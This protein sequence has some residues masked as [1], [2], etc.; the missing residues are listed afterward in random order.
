MTESVTTA[1]PAVLILNWRD[2][3]NP[4]GGGS[5]LYAEEVAAGLARRGHQVTIFCAAHDRA[6]ADELTPDG[7][8]MMRRG[9]PRGVYFRAFWERLRGRLG[10]F[11]VVV[12]V[13]NGLPFLARL[14]A[15]KPVV[16]LIHHVHREQWRVVLGPLAAR[17]GWWVES[18]LS[19][20]VHRACR[21]VTVSEVTRSE[22]AELGV[23]RERVTIVHN[24]TPTAT[25]PR[26]QRTEEPSLLVLGRLVPHKRV[27][28]AIR[29]VAELAPT[30]PGAD[31]HGGRPRLVAGPAA[32]RGRAAR[33]RRPGA[34]HRFRRRRRQARAARLLVAASGTFAQGG[35]GAVGD[36]SSRARHSVGRVRRRG[37][38]RRV[39]PPRR[40]RAAGRRRGPVRG[41]GRPVTWRRRPRGT[42]W[43]LPHSPM[44][45]ISPGTRP[46]RRFAAVLDEVTAARVT[47]PAV[48]LRSR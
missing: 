7:V 23:D 12:D 18:W 3:R 43:A 1:L 11:D 8:R 41:A 2:T 19:P 17:F 31:P 5:E 32:D 26:V 6:P 10:N 37:W 30:H 28:I 34:L 44:P 24:G 22:L 4:E 38:C 45:V 39:D 15:R 36:G 40:D 14:Y 42:G 47:E 20:R 46:T 33:D 35:L 13:Q 21:Y 9:S 29:A 25:G 27:E 48:A 16:L